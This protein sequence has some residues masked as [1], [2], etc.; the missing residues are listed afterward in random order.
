MAKMNSFVRDDVLPSWWAN[1]I[2]EHIAGLVANLRLTLLNATTVRATAVSTD[3]ADVQASIGVDGLWRR[4]SANV[5]RAHPGGA[6]G[7]YDVFVTAK[8]NSIGSVPLPGTDNTDY[9]FALAIVATGGTPA[10]VPGTVDV[11]RK[12]GECWWDGAAITRLEPWTGD[13]RPASDTVVAGTPLA[14]VTPLTVLGQGGQ[15]TLI[16]AGLNTT[17]DDRFVLSG[18]GQ[19]RLPVQGSA[20]GL[21]L[22]GDVAVYRDAADVLRTPDSVRVD[23]GIGIGAAAPAA[24]RLSLAGQ[25]ALTRALDADAGIDLLV[26][27]GAVPRLRIR[28]DGKLEFSDGTNP[29]DVTVERSGTTGLV[30]NNANVSGTLRHTGATVGLFNTTP[31]GRSGSWGAAIATNFTGAT[32]RK[33]LGAGYTMDHMRDVIATLVDALRSIGVIGP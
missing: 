31:T 4:V 19:A 17:G 1:S 29:A 26:G 3:S 2:Q 33:S 23:G 6:A 11:F 13:R 28:A 32:S 24:G 12:V 5:D 27:V 22:G 21:L 7:K 8:N 20:G 10:I 25:I 15:T 30:I 16:Q 14:S 9:A 18:A